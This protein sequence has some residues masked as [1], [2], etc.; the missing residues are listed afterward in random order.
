[1]AS[2][3]CDLERD[4]SL[5]LAHHIGQV[6]VRGTGRVSELGL[7]NGVRAAPLVQQSVSPDQLVKASD[8]VDLNAFHKAGLRG[9]RHGHHN[10]SSASCPS[11]QDER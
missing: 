7:W 8:G 11:S 3:C 10:V 6:W 4:P 2:C 1:M 5:S 9:A